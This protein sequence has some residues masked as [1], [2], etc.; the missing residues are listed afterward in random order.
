ME[1]RRQYQKQHNLAKPKKTIS[2]SKMFKQLGWYETITIAAIS[3]I[4]AA[5]LLTDR[6]FDDN[7]MSV[8]YSAALLLFFGSIV[9]LIKGSEQKKK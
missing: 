2:Y 7:Y 6:Y 1:S 9:V 8:R 3:L 4:I 5:Y